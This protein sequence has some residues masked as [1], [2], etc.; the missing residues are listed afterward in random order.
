MTDTADVVVLGGGLA[1]LTAASVLA[2]RAIV[3]ERELRPGGLVRTEN[4]GGFWFDRVIHLLYFGDPVIERRVLHMVGPD[5]QPCPPVAYV[6]LQEGTVRFPF[7]TNL[8]GLS[9]DAVIRCIHDFAAATF[10]TALEPPRDYQ[11]LLRRT[12][13]EAMCELFFE[14]YN[15]KLW[16]RSLRDLA[17]IGFQ[18]N[19]ARPS[20]TEVL[21]GALDGDD[22]G[23]PYNARGWY[24]VRSPTL[25]S[26][27]WNCSPVPSSVGSRTFASASRCKRSISPG[28]PSKSAWA[29]GQRRCIGAAPVSALCPCRAPLPFADRPRQTFAG[30]V[31]SSCTIGCGPLR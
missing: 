29:P 18:W 23:Q 24:P 13:G 31:P 16:L 15:R 2:D 17:P 14:P 9:R 27:A 11:H 1:G 28:G 26:A 6:E 25:R 4:F 7:Q 3:I 12:F 8:A 19:L 30:I 21:R 5:F 20:L 10:S 22:H